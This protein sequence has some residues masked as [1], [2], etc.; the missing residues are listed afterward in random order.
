MTDAVNGNANFPKIEIRGNYR[1]AAT[2]DMAEIY[3]RNFEE[4]QLFV[5]NFAQSAFL[6][7]KGPRN[8][9]TTPPVILGVGGFGSGHFRISR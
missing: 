1:G 4:I 7:D 5:S 2:H 6:E 8:L 9:A 3:S